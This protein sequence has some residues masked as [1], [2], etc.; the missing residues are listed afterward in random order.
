MRQNQIILTIM[1]YMTLEHTYNQNVR[2]LK[3]FV[4]INK[5]RIS[6][7]LKVNIIYKKLAKTKPQ[8]QHYK[9][10]IVLLYANLKIL[11]KAGC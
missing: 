9:A 8:T 3:R 7:R 11:R 10:K 6:F 5:L 2:L 1:L 4:L